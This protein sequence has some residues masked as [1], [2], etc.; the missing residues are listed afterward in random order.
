LIS[1]KRSAIKSQVIVDFVVDWTEPSNYTEGT[2]PESHW[3]VYCDKTWGNVAARASAILVS[4]SGIKL[5]YATRLQFTKET[6]KYTNN[7][8]EYEVVLLG[9][10]KLRAIGFQNCIIRTYSKVIKCHIE[11]VSTARDAT[12]GKYL[13]LVRK[14]ENY[15]KGFTIEYIKRN[16]NAEADELAKAR[17]TTLHPDV[18]FQ[19]IEYSSVKTIEPKLRM[20]NIIVA[21][22]W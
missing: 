5:R 10:H 17:K 9:L 21:E 16:K 12:L 2:T 11:K 19:T 14:M 15:F 1:K 20:V 8:V 7:I 22:D 4:P 18:F 6:N 13:T 3:L